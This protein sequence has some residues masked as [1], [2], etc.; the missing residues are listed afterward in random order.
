MAN[1]FDILR[2]RDPKREEEIRR[3][4]EEMAAK[5]EAAYGKAPDEA[6]IEEGDW[7]DY[8][9]AG[10]TKKGLLRAL[11]MSAG[12]GVKSTTGKKGQKV[13]TYVDDP[14]AAPVGRTSAGSP[15]ITGDRDPSVQIKAAQEAN[16]SDPRGGL[17]L[18]YEK[19]GSAP[20]ARLKKPQPKE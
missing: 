5:Y 7:F 10:L 11:K 3:G 20:K 8:S 15:K 9:P 18:S 17:T 6:G 1:I 16:A 13:E 12:K 2:G 14:E 19:W 4:A